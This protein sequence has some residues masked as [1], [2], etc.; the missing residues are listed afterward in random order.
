METT[1]TTIDRPPIA[2]DEITADLICETADRLGIRLVR[3]GPYYNRLRSCGCALGV[4]MTTPAATPS[5]ARWP[6]GRGWGT[7][8]P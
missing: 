6:G 4:G 2:V 5:A 8:R 1:S 3:R 7:D